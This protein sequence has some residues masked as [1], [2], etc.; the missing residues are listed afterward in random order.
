LIW[1]SS[2]SNLSW[3]IRLFFLLRYFWRPKVSIPINRDWPR[4]F[5]SAGRI[6]CSLSMG[7]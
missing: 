5:L 3:N 2:L 7:A 1:S 4:S 6:F